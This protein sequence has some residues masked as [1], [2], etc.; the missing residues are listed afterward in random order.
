MDTKIIQF[1]INEII[2]TGEYTLEGIANST[3]I[4]FDVIY[5]AAGG[6]KHSFCATSWAKIVDLYLQ[7]KPDVTEILVKKLLEMR[8]KDQQAFSLLL[9]EI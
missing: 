4:P 5:D 6:M 7:L 8:E 3:R 2:Q 9:N 1:I